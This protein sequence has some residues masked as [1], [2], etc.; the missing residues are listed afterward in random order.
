MKVEKLIN[1]NWYMEQKPYPVH[2]SYDVFYLDICRRLFSIIEELAIEHED[3]IDLDE[4]DCRDLAYV[5]T[6][7][8]ED[9]VNDFGFWKSLVLMH[10]NLFGKR[11]PFSD[12]DFLQA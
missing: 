11:L 3:S 12:K 8:F 5:L 10:K 2:S 7:Y 9:Q 4:E 6:A 1:I